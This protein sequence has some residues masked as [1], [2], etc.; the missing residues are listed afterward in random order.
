MSEAT[1]R[2]QARPKTVEKIESFL[3]GIAEF[4][5]Q[6]YSVAISHPSEYRIS[7][8]YSGTSRS[9]VAKTMDNLILFI[10]E[11]NINHCYIIN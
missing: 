6:S 9:T 8:Y 5:M 11:T 10:I 3:H 1:V 2:R 4:W 7:I